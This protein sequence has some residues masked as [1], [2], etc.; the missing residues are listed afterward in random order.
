MIMWQDILDRQVRYGAIP[1]SQVLSPSG[2]HE[3]EEQMLELET[4]NKQA[5]G[6]FVGWL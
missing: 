2:S 1:V 5:V 6:K 3:L 4:A